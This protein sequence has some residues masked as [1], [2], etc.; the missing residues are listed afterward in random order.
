MQITSSPIQ[1]PQRHFRADFLP[2]SSHWT[3][4]SQGPHPHQVVGRHRHHEQPVD[5]LDAAHHHLVDR[6]DELGRAE[7][8]F[9]QIALALRQRV[10]LSGCDL[11]GSSGRA[12]RG[13]RRGHFSSLLGVAKTPRRILEYHVPK[14]KNLKDS[15][16]CV[17]AEFA[18]TCWAEGIADDWLT[19]KSECERHASHTVHAPVDHYNRW[20]LLASTA[21]ACATNRF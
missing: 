13:C 17:S 5:L 21:W 3:D 9:D 7:A 11:V 18:D 19:P 4:L 2:S 8:L 14:V 6:T 1:P 16:R 15:C 10:A 12:Y 20:R